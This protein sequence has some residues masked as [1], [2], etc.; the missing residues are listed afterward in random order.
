[1]NRNV[2]ID[3]VLLMRTLRAKLNAEM[4]DMSAQERLDYIHRAARSRQTA[5]PGTRQKRI[6]RQPARV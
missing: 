1:M 3:A 6:R 5:R 2:T 4:K